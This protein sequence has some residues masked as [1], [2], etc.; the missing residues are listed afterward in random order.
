M[1]DTPPSSD[2]TVLPFDLPSLRQRALLDAAHAFVITDA[3]QP[4]NP[5]VDVNPA[6]T[7][8]TGYVR[9]RI[10]GRNC[11][12]L[13]GPE[14]DPA[15][16]DV[17][18]EAIATDYP[19]TVTLLNYRADGSSFWNEVTVSPLPDADG[20]R[21]FYIGIQRDVSSR[22][23]AVGLSR[24]LE[25]E[26]ARTRLTTA[27][28]HTLRHELKSPLSIICGYTELLLDA[29]VASL[30]TEQRA[31]LA[32]ILRSGRHLEHLLSAMLD[33]AQ[34]QA[35]TLVFAWDDVAISPLLA[36]LHAEYAPQAAAKQV[37]FQMIVPPSL[38]PLHGDPIRLHQA[39]A[40]VVDNAVR[41]TDTG[42]VTLT[43]IET[44]EQ[45]VIQVSD[46]GRGMAADVLDHLFVGLIP[47]E[48]ELRR[49][50]GGLG[51][52]GALAAG[53]IAAHGGTT[54]AESTPGAGTIVTVMLPY[55]DAS[56]RADI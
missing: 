18:R 34:L 4:D 46:T 23:Q 43:V 39:L 21:R 24:S 20:H 49:E 22:M 6:F 33:L 12:F 32:M 47:G 7:A 5:I 9:E 44:L 10:L 2:A 25:A 27:V 35:G 11:R 40:Q 3:C 37:E 19:V 55:R 31:D 28:M 50:F 36:R 56:G 8:L 29:R 41:F 53:L 26:Q 52:G 13:Q 16:V 42:T 45:L 14:T 38:A 51:I 54:K 1:P 30:T 15:A 48:Q 17:L